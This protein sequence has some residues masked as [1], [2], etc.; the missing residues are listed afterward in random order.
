[1]IT[2]VAKFGLENTAYRHQSA[3]PTCVI[4]LGYHTVHTNDLHTRMF[5]LLPYIPTG[6]A[7]TSRHGETVESSFHFDCAQVVVF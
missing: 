7:T 2:K 6:L 4:V 5:L 1:M 3:S